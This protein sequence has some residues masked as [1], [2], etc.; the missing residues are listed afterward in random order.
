[1]T[2][3][4]AIGYETNLPAA[5]P[6]ALIVREVDVP[7]LGPHD[8]LVEVEAVSVNPVD[9]KLRAGAPSGGF[10]VLGFDAAGTV[11]EV[12]SEVTLFTPGDVVFYA[13]SI[14]RP[15]TN[16]R[17]HAVDERIVGRKPKTLSFADSAALPLTAITAWE[18]L[19]D[20]LGLAEDSTGTLLIVGA[21]GGV[22]SI[23]LQL[24]E[25]LC[26]G[27][28]VIAT[29]SDDERAAWVRGLGAEHVVN[30]HQDLAAQVLANAPEGVE[31]AFT[32][33]SDGQIG[34]Y[35]Q[36]VRPF[37]H[38][39]AI[40]DGPRDVSPLKGKSIAWHWELMFTRP[41]Q[42]TPDMI[43]QHRL[44]NTI[45]DLVDDGRLRPTTTTTSAPISAT[46]LREAHELVESGRTV[47][48]IVIHGWA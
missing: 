39:V 31:W 44:L 20:R 34:T 29:A 14:D 11:R 2:T 16:Q 3:T 25:A 43:E 19:F 1:M 32:A 8:L 48:K 22:G 30:H 26:P 41:L 17:F 7:T 27:V 45:A 18:S 9:V 6:G 47:G 36:I 24:A 23:M 40:D 5:D 21:T 28:T 46:T 37:G 13:G 4:T 10:R 38:V 42:Q 35:A 15:G 12:G 33:H